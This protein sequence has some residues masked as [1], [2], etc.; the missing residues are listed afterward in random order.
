MKILI[1]NGNTD[2]E[3]EKFD[4][5]LELLVAGLREE[6]HECIYI[7]LREKR[8]IQCTGCW[9]CWVKNPGEC[10][11]TDD[12]V[13]I[14]QSLIKSGLVI[15]ASPLV[16]GFVSS[17]MKKTM[18]KMIPLLLPYTSLVQGECHHE[19]RYDQYPLF[20]FIYSNPTKDKSFEEISRDMLSRFALNFRSHLA[21]SFSIHSPLEEIINEIDSY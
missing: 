18:D 20:G 14:R 17:P 19:K 6:R 5:P 15:L 8:I 4:R 11:F 10:S 21:F 3:T 7:R 16:A 12:T 9:D 2:R 13:E 1:L